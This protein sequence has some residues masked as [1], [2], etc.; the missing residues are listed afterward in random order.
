MRLQHTPAPQDAGH[1]FCR[2]AMTCAS[3]FASAFCSAI[4]ISLV[5][6]IISLFKLQY[7]VT[8]N[9]FVHRFIYKWPNEPNA[10]VMV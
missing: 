6:I 9:H 10:I 5:I 3:E 2:C 8:N 1:A 7:I 4:Y